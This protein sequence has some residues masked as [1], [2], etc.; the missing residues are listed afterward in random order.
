MSVNHLAFTRETEDGIE[1]RAFI[2]HDASQHKDK[3]HLSSLNI[4]F[5]ASENGL[6][7]GNEFNRVCKI[8]DKI[9]AEFKAYNGIHIG[10]V[11]KNGMMRSWFRSRLAP[12][13]ELLI[14]TSLFKKEK[15]ALTHFHDPDW[16]IGNQQVAP[17]PLEYERAL[18]AML[19]IQLGQ[20]GDVSEA[21]RKVDFFAY[22]PSRDH[23]SQFAAE[24][25]GNG[26]TTGEVS[27]NDGQYGLEFSKEMNVIP[28]EM[29]ERCL[30]IR[31][32]VKRYGGDFDGWAC[33]IVRSED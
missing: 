17:T 5:G 32:I 27:E 19:H 22:F 14:K 1:I 24:V 33:P 15:F 13:T 21:V 20:N 6:P 18:N 2:E 4:P 25:S 12:P 10:H 7:E 11:I 23:A 30:D 9:A 8:E 31:S 29:S 26:F 16:E 3:V 28:S